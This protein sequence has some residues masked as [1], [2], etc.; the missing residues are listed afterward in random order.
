MNTGG[1]GERW[2]LAGVRVLTQAGAGRQQPITGRDAHLMPHS[3][4]ASITEFLGSSSSGIPVVEPHP[5]P[6]AV[7]GQ[8]TAVLSCRSCFNLGMF[9]TSPN[10]I[11]ADI[12][13]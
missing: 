13:A 11:L 12:T 10:C 3:T 1:G 4:V 6:Q 5:I 8:S 7:S 9:H 2:Q